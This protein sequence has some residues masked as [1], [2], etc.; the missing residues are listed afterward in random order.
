VAEYLAMAI[1]LYDAEGRL[2]FY[3]EAAEAIVGKPFEDVR[4]IEVGE[5]L[6]L[7]QFTDAGGQPILL[8]EMPLAVA[9]RQRRPAQVVVGLRGLDGVDRRVNITSIP[10]EG[11]G[12]VPL[13][14]M[15][16]LWEVDGA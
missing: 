7:F 2:L 1:F 3:N 12:G 4:P 13:G 11:Q 5:W 14:A 9:T 10:L 15:S 6:S 8:D 16:I